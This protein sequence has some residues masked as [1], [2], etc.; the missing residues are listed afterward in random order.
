MTRRANYVYK[1]TYLLLLLSIK[2]CRSVEQKEVHIFV[3]LKRA[4]SPNI[5]HLEVHVFFLRTLLF[6]TNVSLRADP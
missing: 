2:E 3:M 1:H 6:N 4:V 5:D